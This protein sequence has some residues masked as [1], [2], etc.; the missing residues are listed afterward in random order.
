[1]FYKK[2]NKNKDDFIYEKWNKYVCQ[3]QYKKG[4]MKALFLGMF[5]L[6]WFWYQATNA[7]YVD[8]QKEPKQATTFKYVEELGLLL[9]KTIIK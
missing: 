1:M 8:W 7:G 4:S 2:N 6:V 5:A 3:Y 9:I